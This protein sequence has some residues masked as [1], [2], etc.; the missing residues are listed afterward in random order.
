MKYFVTLAEE[1]NGSAIGLE[2]QILDD[3]LH[4]DAKMGRNGNANSGI[5][6]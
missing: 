3:T 4:G 2:Y 1:I 6:V 5:V